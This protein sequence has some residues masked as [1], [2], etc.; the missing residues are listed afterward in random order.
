MRF[1]GAERGNEDTRRGFL[2]DPAPAPALLEGPFLER[3]LPAEDVPEARPRRRAEPA[4]R[5]DR[6]PHRIARRLDA[7]RRAVPVGTQAAL[8]EAQVR[9]VQRAQRIEL[10]RRKPG[11]KILA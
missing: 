6:T 3:A 8:A 1:Q 5:L 10:S 7:K 11:T 2:A 4:D 9:H